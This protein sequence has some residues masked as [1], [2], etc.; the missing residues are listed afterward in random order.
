MNLP[1]GPTRFQ[2]YTGTLCEAAKHC[3]IASMKAAV[4]D[5]IEIND[6]STDIAVAVDGTW[7]RRGHTSLNGVVTVTSMDNGK[8]LDVEVLSKYCHK[9]R[10]IKDNEKL[11]LHKESSECSVNFEGSSGNM[12][13]AGAVN[14]FSRSVDMFG[15][16][17]VKYLGDGDSKSFK[18]VVEAKPYGDVSVEKLECIGHVQKRMGTRLRKLRKDMKGIKLPD[19]KPLSGKGRLTDKEIDSLQNYY[20]MAIRR[21]CDSEMKMKQDI[22]AIYFHKLSTD[23]E[24]CHALCPKGPTSWCK[25]NRAI[26]AGEQYSHRHSLPVEVCN[27]IKPV[28][29]SLTDQNLLRKCLHG[30]TQNP[31]ESFNSVIWSRIP[32]TV[33]VVKDTLNLGVYDAVVSFNDGNV[34]RVRLLQRLGIKPGENM[35]KACSELDAVR[36]KKADYEVTMMARK[37][38]M[39]SRNAKRAREDKENA[40]DPGYGAGMF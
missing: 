1:S 17:Y 34:G 24:S 9:C 10:F 13:A 5:A 38:R 23:T 33:F 31:N 20:G 6:N 14:I 40:D 11:K 37:A 36:V 22:W 28:F 21:N 3:A 12:E 29:R 19:G 32:K 4:S 7:Q 30:K 8:V 18:S 26:A 15:V 16:R 35:V 27:V 2:K 39:H 25:Y